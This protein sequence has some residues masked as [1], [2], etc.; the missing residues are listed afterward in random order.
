MERIG[1]TI[2]MGLA[3]LLVA[4]L[5]TLGGI[6]TMNGNATSA[7]TTLFPAA[8]TTPQGAVTSDAVAVNSLANQ[9][10][11]TDTA[12]QNGVLDARFAVQ[13]VG[14]AVVTIVN[15][16]QI[17]MRGRFG[18]AQSQ[19]AE[20]LGSGVIISSEGYIVTNQHVVAGQQS[21]DVIFADGT[22]V[23]ATLVGE[24]AY[25]DIAVIKVDAN[26]PAV[27]QFGDSDKLEAG[28]PVVAIGTALGDFENTVTAGIV[29][30]L[31]RQLEDG[32]T[33]LQDLI[34]TDAAINHGNSGGALLD[35]DGNII[36]INTAV[37]RNDGTMGSVA[38]G[39]GFAIPSNT[40]KTV[41]EQLMK[42]G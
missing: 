37:V 30:G 36:G 6:T 9:A 38:E 17:N 41:V 19:T 28:Q 1:R 25:T 14:S 20:A 12:Q 27:A 8:P 16:M 21:L 33:S 11:F 13:Q 4:V 2:K 7:I 39:L 24:D 32:G 34:Q 3:A 31:H 23:A 22:R 35:L 10:T 15:T 18:P 26:M 29:S 5:L 42:G 40:V